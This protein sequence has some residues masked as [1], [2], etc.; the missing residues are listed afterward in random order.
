MKTILPLVLVLLVGQQVVAQGCNE[1]FISEYCEGSGNNKGF[2]IYN[3]TD[4]AIDLGP[5]VYERWSNGANAVSDELNLQGTIEPYGVWVVVNGQTEDVDLGGGSVSPAVDPLMQVYAN[6]LDNPYPAPTYMNGD[7]A[8]VLTKDG[9]VVDIFGKPGEDP[10][11]A[12]TDNAES[13]YTSEDGGTWLTSN[14]TLKRKFDVTEGVTTVPLVFDTFLEWDTLPNNTWTFLGSHAC[15]CDP[16]AVPDVIDNVNENQAIQFELFPNPV[17]NGTFTITTDQV[18]SKIEV[19][20]QNGQLVKVIQQD[21]VV[22]RTQF[23][24][25]DLA[26]GAYIVNVHLSNKRTF[27]QRL[28]IQ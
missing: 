8:C 3:P 6:Q 16:N 1:L 25:S 27:S 26:E 9:Q 5:Y 28:L 21:F 4:Q 2:E 10:G 19:Y 7:D 22:G 14:H 24:V 15:S 20:N 13:G 12:W 23:D 17:S 18:M 11:T